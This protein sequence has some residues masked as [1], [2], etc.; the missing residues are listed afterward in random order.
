MIL[1][2]DDNGYLELCSDINDMCLKK[3]GNRIDASFVEM[4]RNTILKLNTNDKIKN[5]VFDVTTLNLY[6]DLNTFI[7]D[8]DNDVL[9]KKYES[10]SFTQHIY[11]NITNA[12]N[13]IVQCIEKFDN[14][15][16]K[17]DGE[18]TA[19]YRQKLATRKYDLENLLDDVRNNA[20]LRGIVVLQSILN[21]YNKAINYYLG[22]DISQIHNSA[23]HN[24]YAIIADIIKTYNKEACD[25]V[26]DIRI[27]TAKKFEDQL[28]EL[29]EEIYKE[30]YEQM[31]KIINDEKEQ[32]LQK[33][34]AILTYDNIKNIELFNT[35]KQQHFIKNIYNEWEQIFIKK[36]YDK[37]M[38]VRLSIDKTCKI[39]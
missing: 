39:E 30:H 11:L 8:I 24:F 26:E 6:K 4:A 2:C 22:L 7:E 25:I 13:V 14:I 19:K 33:L 29:I 31:I 12:Y 23:T 32:Y 27:S 9:Y 20:I 35:Y 28:K 37:F 17:C 10:A 18:V 38:N 15:F 5:E 1:Q 16:F 36:K 34:N 3:E 21:D